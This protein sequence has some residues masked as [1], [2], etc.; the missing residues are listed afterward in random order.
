MSVSLMYHIK[1]KAKV[2]K[3]KPIRVYF[4]QCPELSAHLLS[5]F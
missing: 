2:E 1:K 4:L 5:C 3:M